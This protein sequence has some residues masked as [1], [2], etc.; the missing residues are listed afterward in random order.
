MGMNGGGTK[1][2]GCSGLVRPMEECLGQWVVDGGEGAAAEDEGGGLDED[3][4]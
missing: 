2:L 1:L 4:N 3:G